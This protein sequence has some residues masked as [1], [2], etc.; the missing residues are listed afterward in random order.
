MTTFSLKELLICTARCRCLWKIRRKEQRLEGLS[1]T[2]ATI[3]Y[4]VLKNG[5][6]SKRCMKHNNFVINNIIRLGIVTG[7]YIELSWVSIEDLMLPGTINHWLPHFITE[8]RKKFIP[9]QKYFINT[10]HFKDDENLTTTDNHFRNSVF[11]TLILVALYRISYSS[12]WSPSGSMI[13][14]YLWS[15]LTF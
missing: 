15:Y 14:L 8:L 3:E 5:R 4:W 7:L 1:D 6:S 9:T 2:C 13:C 11:A 10:Q 12:I